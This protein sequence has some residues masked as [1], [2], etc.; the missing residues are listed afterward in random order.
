MDE[1]QIINH[2]RRKR[3]TS[4]SNA[5]SSII[6][7]ERIV[8]PN[9]KIRAVSDESPFSPMGT[10]TT[11][12]TAQGATGGIFYSEDHPSSS[13]INLSVDSAEFIAERTRGLAQLNKDLD[14][15]YKRQT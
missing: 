14:A 12:E 8:I 13:T 2:C 6:P 15:A 5:S 9:K 11:F 1:S 7:P 4:S 3:P 10:Q